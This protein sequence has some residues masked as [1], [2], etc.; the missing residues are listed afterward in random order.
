MREDTKVRRPEKVIPDTAQRP[1]PFAEDLSEGVVDQGQQGGPAFRRGKDPRRIFVG[2]VPLPDYLSSVGLGWVVRL[3]EI[4]WSLEYNKFFSRYE[5]TG[6]HPFHPAVII[7]LIIYGMLKRQWSLRELENLARIDVDA[8]LMC[9]GIQPDHSTIGHFIVRHQ[10]TLTEEFFVESTRKIATRLKVTAGT[11]AIDGTVIEAAASHYR[12]L[13]AEAAREAAKKARQKSL[14]AHDDTKAAVKATLAEDAAEAA[15]ERQDR[16]KRDGKDPT[17]VRVSPVEPEAVV[18]PQKNQSRRPSYTPS[19]MGHESGLIVGQAT[20][21]S[22]ETAVVPSLLQQHEEVVGDTPSLSLLDAGYF[23]TGIL[24]MFFENGQDVLIPAG[25]A[26]GADDIEKQP[27]GGKKFL[28]NQF[29]YEAEADEFTCPA[30]QTLERETSASDK[31]GRYVRYRGIAC[32]GCPMA[33][34]C[35]SSERGRTL[36]R[37]EGDELKEAMIEVLRHPK[38]REDY[39]AR[40]RIAER[41]LAELKSRQG[42][43]RFHRRGQSGAAV[44]FSLHCLAFNLGLLVGKRGTCVIGVV[45]LARQG[46]AMCLF[47]ALEIASGTYP[48]AS[49]RP[50]SPGASMSTPPPGPLRGPT[51]A[52]SGGGRKTHQ[53]ISTVSVGRG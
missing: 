43:R 31:N 1:L 16:R 50:T 38:A 18:Q 5:G 22:S 34:C 8:W 44:E 14:Q 17:S 12:T 37:Y 51:P 13:T 28:K 36:K 30:G 45:V 53:P 33:E 27:R 6:R 10:D 25:K 7:G 39:R 49:T 42:L 3:R 9:G 26:K 23:A 46:T 24:M 11:A 2:D 47:F 35:T 40:K 15:V 32:S 52:A 41:P 29:R 21:P 4:V 19:I 20:H 48:V